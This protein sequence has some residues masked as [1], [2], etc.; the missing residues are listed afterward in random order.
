MCFVFFI[1]FSLIEPRGPQAVL[2]LIKGFLIAR[3][4]MLDRLEQPVG[5]HVFV[6]FSH[7]LQANCPT[8]SQVEY[9][10]QRP[11]KRTGELAYQ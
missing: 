4:G 1:L 6:E 11:V 2:P 8:D 3:L 5:V 7:F 9:L 10:I